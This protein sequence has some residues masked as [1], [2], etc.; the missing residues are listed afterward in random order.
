M[1]IMLIGPSLVQRG[2][3][4]SVL[5]GL[6]G[7]LTAHGVKVCTVATT[8]EGHQWRGVLAFLQAWSSVLG[9]CL[10]RKVDV[11]HLHMASRGSCLRKLILA[12]TCWIFRMPFIIH[13]HGAEYRSF[14]DHE[15]GPIGRVLVRF[16]FRRATRVIALSIA[17]KEWLEIVMRLRHVVVVFN[18][19]P[20][21]STTSDYNERPTVLFLGRL[22]ARK[23][24]DELIVAMREVSRQVPD[25]ILELGGDGDIDFYRQQAIDLPNVR[26][27][28][29][30]DDVGRQAALNR[31][32][33]YCLPSWNEGLPMSVLE[34]MS[35]GLPVISTPVGGIPEAV[36]DG[37]TGL[38][39]QPGDTKGL[40]TA[41]CR[42]LL[43]P[44]MATAMGSKAKVCHR[45]RFS[46]ESMGRGCLEV[47]A[48]C[49]KR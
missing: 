4:V 46:T 30:I 42:L 39:V 25:A 38:L 45:D 1:N 48:S 29:W 10:L 12:M 43:D 20:P 49:V 11:V 34:A 5:H 15:L 28:G 35:A 19:V 7:F 9:T 6:K 18:G 2:G 21:I 32:T 47:Y 26:F 41:I 22:C 33:V 31:A 44:A 37:V 8:S 23:G 36:A 13:L 40:A 24:T 16:L 27:L 14:H 3:V 17:W